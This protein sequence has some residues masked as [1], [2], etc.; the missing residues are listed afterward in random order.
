MSIEIGSGKPRSIDFTFDGKPLAVRNMSLRL[1]LKMQL[2]GD[3]DGLP[4]ELV[5]EIIAEC[6]VDKK[7]NTVW[8]VDEVLDFDLE[9][10]MKLF[11]EVSGATIGDAEKN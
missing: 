2:Q 3:E 10:M 7:G 11:S 9:P 4:A 8:G 5:A 1:G 6:V